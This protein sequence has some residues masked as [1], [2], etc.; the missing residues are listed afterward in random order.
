M[1]DIVMSYMGKINKLAGTDYKPFNYYGDPEAENIVIAMGSITDTIKQVVNKETKHGMKIGVIEVHLYRPF[2]TR[3]LE[4]VLQKQLKK[5]IAVLDR[6]KEAGS[7]GEPLYLDV[8]GALK[9]KN[10]EIVGGRFGLSSKNTTRSDIFGVYSV[11]N[12]YTRA[13]FTI[14]YSR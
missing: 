8:I 1:P 14:K 13:N 4:S 6:T 3:Y 11:A 12:V 2:S 9:D 5:R 10:I 7:V